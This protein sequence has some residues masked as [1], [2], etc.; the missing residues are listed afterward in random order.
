MEELARY[1]CMSDDETPVIVVER[2]YVHISRGGSGTR[3]QLGARR[4]TLETGE[5][6]RYIDDELF[7]V[8]HSGELV[9]RLR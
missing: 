5:M 8:V 2:R 9:R 3:R 1:R 6:V 4:L 7:E